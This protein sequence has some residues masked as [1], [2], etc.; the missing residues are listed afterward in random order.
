MLNFATKSRS[1]VKNPHRFTVITMLRLLKFCSKICK[2][3]VV[4]IFENIIAGIVEMQMTDYKWLETEMKKLWKEIFHDSDDYINLFFEN[5]FNPLLTE[6][7]IIDGRLVAMMIGVPY[8]FVLRKSNSQ[9]LD[10]FEENVDLG[11]TK[12]VSKSKPKTENILTLSDTVGR[13]RGLYLCGLATDEF[14]R[15]QGLMSKL[16]DRIY[17][18]ATAENFDFLFLIP[19]DDDLRKYYRKRNWIDAFVRNKIEITKTDNFKFDASKIKFFNSTNDKEI[20]SKILKIYNLFFKNETNKTGLTLIHDFEKFKVAIKENFISGGEI[21]M[22]YDC[23]DRLSG[24]AFLS[25]YDDKIIIPKLCFDTEDD[26]KS[27]FAYIAEKYQ[28]SK[29]EIFSYADDKLF[30]SQFA[31]KISLLP[32]GMIKIIQPSEILKFSTTSTDVNKFSILVKNQDLPKNSK[33]FTIKNREVLIHEINELKN[34]N[35]PSNVSPN[36]LPVDFVVNLS[37]LTGHIFLSSDRMQ[38]TL[39]EIEKFITPTDCVGN[40]S[41]LLD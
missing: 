14:Y 11:I 15:N 12:S 40:I 3:V 1:I 17:V 36:S 28:K 21:I 22:S 32:Y 24:F 38:H 7:E 34:N 5:N 8:D 29:V 27:L 6:Y 20:E 16:L 37:D 33:I 41:L 13:L 9:I 2:S 18:K 25:E 35:L 19:V 26:V 31:D 30:F 23:E 4:R 10:F 39:P